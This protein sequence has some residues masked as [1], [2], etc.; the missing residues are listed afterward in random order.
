MGFFA[1]HESSTFI[2]GEYVEVVVKTGSVDVSTTLNLY[3]SVEEIPSL[4]FP[5]FSQ[6]VA[7]TLGSPKSVTSFS[8]PIST[9]APCKFALDKYSVSVLSYIV[10]SAVVPSQPLVSAIRKTG[11]S[12]PTGQTGGSAS[13]VNSSVVSSQ[14][15][16]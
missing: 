6:N 12:S 2:S 7:T 3:V 13:S 9:G 14:M 15:P 5:A 10:N 1:L 8:M 4:P 16:Q 11:I